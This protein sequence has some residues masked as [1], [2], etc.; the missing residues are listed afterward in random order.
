M[1]LIMAMTGDGSGYVEIGK[2][3][4]HISAKRNLAKIFVELEE[5]LEPGWRIKAYMGIHSFT[6]YPPD[7]QPIIYSITVN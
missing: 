1:Y 3:R 7:S 6:V 2:F 4:S 5:N